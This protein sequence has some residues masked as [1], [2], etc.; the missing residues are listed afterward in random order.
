MDVPIYSAEDSDPLSGLKLATAAGGSRMDLM[1]SNPQ[2]L[3]RVT[4][5][6]CVPRNIPDSDL[7]IQPGTV[8]V[9]HMEGLLSGSW[10]PAR[11]PP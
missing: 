3:V 9:S 10:S 2:G 11:A 1:S 8:T 5:S 7:I 4:A 6:A